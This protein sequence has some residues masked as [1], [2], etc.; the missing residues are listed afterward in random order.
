MLGGAV[1]Q[2]MDGSDNAQVNQALELN[3][4]NQATTWTNPNSNTT[5]TVTPTRTF[6]SPTGD[7]CRDYTVSALANGQT[8]QVYATS[9]RG[10]SGG[11]HVVSS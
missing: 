11:W 10:A 8:Q 3:K 7:P 2:S 4:T 1:G 5:Y 6:S 9:C